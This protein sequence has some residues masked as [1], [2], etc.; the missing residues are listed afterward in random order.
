MVRLFQPERPSWKFSGSA[1]AGLYDFKCAK[2]NTDAYLPGA[3]LLERK[4]TDLLTLLRFYSNDQYHASALRTE[5]TPMS[6]FARFIVRLI[7]CRGYT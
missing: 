4:A 7:R 6:F 5:R 1:F 3:A 2:L